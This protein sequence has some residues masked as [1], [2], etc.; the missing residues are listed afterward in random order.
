SSSLKRNKEMWN[1]IPSIE[2][3]I[4]VAPSML[5]QSWMGSDFTNDD[6]INQSS[7][8]VDYTHELLRQEDYDGVSCWVVAA[9]PKPNAPVVWGKL[10][11]WVSVAE[12]NL[13]QVEYYDEFDDLINTMS[14]YAVE[15]LGGRLIPTRLEMRPAD[16]PQQKTVMVYHAAEFDFAME[17]NFFSQSRMKELRQ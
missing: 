14:N 6:L 10:Q 2:R 7:I 4:K 3:I 9:T 11:L 15:E 1:W 16:K 12:Y 8:V 17:E 5:G 13:R